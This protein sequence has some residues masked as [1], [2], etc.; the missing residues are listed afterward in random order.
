MADSGVIVGVCIG[1]AAAILLTVLILRSVIY[2][3]QQ[4]RLLAALQSSCH[5]TFPRTCRSNH[6]ILQAESIAIERLGKFDR[7]L[8]PGWHVVCCF[9]SPRTFQWRKT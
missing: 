6:R 2:I 7:I 9:E 4:V 5:R 3:V 1:L 8:T